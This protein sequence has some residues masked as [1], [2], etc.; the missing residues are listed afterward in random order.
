MI[1]QEF[2]SIPEI[3]IRLVFV[4]YYDFLHFRSSPAPRNFECPC[5][6]RLSGLSRIPDYIQE[7]QISCFPGCDDFPAFLGAPE[8]FGYPVFPDDMLFRI[9]KCP[10]ISQI[11]C[12][13]WFSCFSGNPWYPRN[14]QVSR[15]SRITCFFRFAGTPE[16]PGWHVF[17]SL[18]VFLSVLGS[19]ELVGCPGFPG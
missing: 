13:Y 6:S 9:S 19:P 1:F 8:I 17:N 15:F 10:R 16:F 11:S 18:H 4:R 5:F 2:P 3:Y 12:F 14:F 7:V